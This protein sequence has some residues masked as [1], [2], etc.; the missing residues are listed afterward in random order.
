[1]VLQDLVN[2]S[3]Y[4]I[5]SLASLNTRLVNIDTLNIRDGAST[6]ITISSQD[7]QNMVDNA[8]A[9]QLYVA[10]NSGD[11]LNVSLSTGESMGISSITS[12]ANGSTY[13]D[14]TIFNS[15][16]TQVAQIH[17]QTA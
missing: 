1:M 7:I 6:A 3:S 15:S 13:T 17:W 16:N 5:T 11:S 4:N 12:A 10:A 14:Y 8:N 9:S 2:G